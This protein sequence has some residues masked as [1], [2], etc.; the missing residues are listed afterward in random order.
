[1]VEVGPLI[2]YVHYE[3]LGI[4]Y[5]ARPASYRPEAWQENILSGW[6]KVHVKEQ[7]VT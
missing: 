7:K 6:E 4:F 1:M 5:A 2:N 3:I